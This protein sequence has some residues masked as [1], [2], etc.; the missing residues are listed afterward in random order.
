MNLQDLFSEFLRHGLYLRN[1]S[2]RTVHTYQQGFTSFQAAVA[3]RPASTLDGDVTGLL[4]NS[5]DGLVLS[6]ARLEAWVIWMR[7][8]GLTP[9]GVNM[10][11]RTM[12]SFC[13]WLHAEGHVQT[14]LRVKLLPNPSKPL[15]GLS[16]AELRVLAGHKA[17]G[18]YEVR[19][20]VLT[21]CLIDTG[22][23]IDEALGL[24]FKNV[25]FDNLN[26][27]VLGK[28]NKERIV[29]F[30][31]EFRK[32]L[33]RYTSRNPGRYVFAARS[34]QRLMYRNAYR[35]IKALFSR[36]DIDGEHVHPH[37]FR[38]FF[39]VNYL[40]K[41]GDLYRLSRILGHTSTQTTTLYLRSMTAEQVAEGHQSPLTS[42]RALR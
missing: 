8:R 22:I 11:L 28:G 16:D 19:A 24:E 42:L 29:P 37:A 38:H 3:E 23:R 30:S 27:K 1:W 21:L 12:N 18:R 39:A 20:W 15:R 36:L 2:K 35:D 40:R 5:D 31:L 6:K 41:G 33:F 17:Q 9:G 4:Q 25:D 14:R 13:S 10:Y 7:E 26:L 32:H 34:G